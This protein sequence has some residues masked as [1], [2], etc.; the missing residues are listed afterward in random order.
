MNRAPKVGDRVRY[1]GGVVTGPCVGTV[2]AIYKKELWPD[3]FYDDPD[4][5]AGVTHKPTGL[6]PEKDWHVRMRVDELPERWPY[7]GASGTDNIFAPAVA[8]LR[9]VSR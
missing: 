1:V 5:V 6:A 4:A 3:D 9:K 2:E 7:G 8:S